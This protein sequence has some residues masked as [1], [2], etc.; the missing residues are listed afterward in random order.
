MLKYSVS[1]TPAGFWQIMLHPES[2]ALTTSITPFGRFKFKRLPFGIS[3]APKV[4]QKRRRE[5]LKRLN[6]VVELMD[7]FMMYGEAEQEHDESLCQ[8]LQRFWMHSKC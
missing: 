5:C 2:S 8:V 1:L 3:S 6:G 7:E 4:F